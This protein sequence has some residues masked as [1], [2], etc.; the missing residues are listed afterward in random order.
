MLNRISVLRCLDQ[1]SCLGCS[2]RSQRISNASSPIYESIRRFS[3]VNSRSQMLPP[4]RFSEDRLRET[5]AASHS[6]QQKA[7]VGPWIPTLLLSGVTLGI[8][9][10]SSYKIYFLNDEA[11][12]PY[13]VKPYVFEEVLTEDQLEDLRNITRDA[14]LES[15]AY[16]DTVA[17][18][19]G[20]P[21]MIESVSDI[22]FKF[23]S[24]RPAEHVVK[25]IEVYRK[26]A[27]AVFPSTRFSVRIF[28]LEE[29]YTALLT[30]I[31][32]AIGITANEDEEDVLQELL[33]RLERMNSKTWVNV[34][35]IAVIQGS[36]LRRQATESGLTEN[37]TKCVVKFQGYLDLN[38]MNAVTIQGGQLT[39]FKDGKEV[40]KAQW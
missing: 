1:V 12:F 8:L 30:P 36:F 23:P 29:A 6:L 27:H 38:R 7:G 21:L 17:A 2:I 9:G 24:D 16:K 18:I 39:L 25:G 11:F 13:W 26:T 35:G 3:T 22:E 40:K 33:T 37:D 14:L 15:L 10:Y 20:L 34:T 28:S 19:V 31:S 5:I 4:R 32:S